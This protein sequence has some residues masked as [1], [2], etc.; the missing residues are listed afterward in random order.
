MTTLIVQPYDWIEKEPQSVKTIKGFSVASDDNITIN[1]WALDRDSNA[2]LVRFD[3]FPVSCYIEL[4]SLVNNRPYKWT[5]GSAGTVFKSIT[6]KIKY[7]ELNSEPFHYDFV[8][9]KKMYYYRL[10]R[11]YPMIVLYFRN[12]TAMRNC[13]NKVLKYSVKTVWGELECKVWENNISV[14]RKMLTSKQVKYASWFKVSAIKISDDVK[15]S[16]IENEYSGDWTTLNSIQAS[17]CE[18]WITSPGVLAFDIE[19]YSDNPRKFTDEYNALHT[20]YMISCIYQRYGKRETR[21]RVGI[22]IGDCGKIDDEKLLNCEI[23]VVNDEVELVEAFAKVIN[24]L[25]PEIITGYNIMG[26]DYKY[27]FYRNA[28]FLKEWPECGRIIGEKHNLN[29]ITW[30]SGVGYRILQFVGMEGRI[31][32]DLS[33]LARTDYKLD[34]YDLDTVCKSFLGRTKH[35]VSAVEMFQ[36]YEQMNEAVENSSP[37]EEQYQHALSETTKVMAYCIQDSEL[38]IDLMEKL[39]VWVS[40]V[41][42]SSIVGTRIVDLYTRGQQIRCFSQLYDMASQNGF[43]IDKRNEDFGKYGGGFVFDPVTGLHDNVICLDFAS[44]YPSIIM[45][46]NICYTT[47]VPPEYDDIV[48]DEECNVIV[49]DDIVKDELGVKTAIPRRYRFIKC[50]PGILPRLVDHLV[51][52]RRAV[53]SQIPGVKD[54]VIKGILNARQLALKVSGN[55]FY[56]FVGVQKGGKMPFV[57]AAKSIT[58]LGRQLIN[59]VRDYIEIKY[60]GQM[61]YGDTDSVMMG[62]GITNMSECQYWG[63]LLA[64]EISG[65]KKGDPLPAATSKDQVHLED[66]E[67]LFPSPLRMEY[68]KGMRI[69]CIK[70]KKYAALLISKKGQFKMKPIR[71]DDGNV[72]GYTDEYD[73]LKKGI[74]LARRDNPIVLRSIYGTILEAIMSL[75]PFEFSFNLLVDHIHKLVSGKV[76]IKDLSIIKGLGANYK[77]ES[78]NMKVFSERLRRDGKEVK[79]GDRLEYVVCT[80][81]DLLLGNRMKLLEEYKESNGTIEIDYTYYLE[82]VLNNPINQ[83]LEIGY[84]NIITLLSESVY[85]VSNNR[86]AN[87]PISKPVGFIQKCLEFGIS[88]DD[89]KNTV[90]YNLDSAN[91]KIITLE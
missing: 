25:D 4:P 23:M 60:N 83:L 22:I 34:K 69:F 16:T 8:P 68:E 58:A 84:N 10:G 6:N 45:A 3:T 7:Y 73:M 67:G 63:E 33:V 65:V 85:F 54:P 5:A 72:T 37:G 46:Y 66:K 89:I 31:N 14:V 20:A 36:I 75:K 87:T 27:L 64:Q 49:F 2:H 91:N 11:L 55:S 17:E 39:N 90:R 15:I 50:V 35:D 78:C 48:K 70:K 77:S 32:I 44:L 81:D 53:R 28:R 12:N 9:K 62:L 40:L 59:K 41:E 13:I 71:D 30:S 88:P 18:G 74:V 57:E 82:H 29:E 86:K 19:S 47:F 51:S 42:L 61:V 1:C 21:K 52:S 80:G 79:P 26:Y 24:D 76:E 43:I 38:V 56:G